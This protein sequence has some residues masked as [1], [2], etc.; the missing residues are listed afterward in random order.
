MSPYDH[1]CHALDVEHA[2]GTAARGYVEALCG[3]TMPGADLEI[4]EAPR[5][6]LCVPCAVA[7]A[8]RLPD[9]GRFGRFT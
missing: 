1:A 3:H 6:A 7:A 4:A 5:G 8:E 9:P 2:A